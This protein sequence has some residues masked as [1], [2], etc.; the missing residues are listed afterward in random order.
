M[1]VTEVCLHSFL[2]SVL[3]GGERLVSRSVHLKHWG[4]LPVP[5]EKEGSADHGPGLMF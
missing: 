2:T 1:G 3:N 5:V 4:K